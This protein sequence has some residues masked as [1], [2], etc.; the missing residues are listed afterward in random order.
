MATSVDPLSLPAA[1]RA[2]AASLQP[3]VSSALAFIQTMLD[4]Q[5]ATM[6]Q[7]TCHCCG[8]SLAQCYGDTATKA[9]KAC[10][11]L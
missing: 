10:N 6:E 9:G 1:Y 8:K 2:E 7:V 3:N 4:E 11:P 5:R